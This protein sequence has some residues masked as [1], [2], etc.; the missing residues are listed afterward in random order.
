MHAAVGLGMN[1]RIQRQCID[2]G[3]KAVEEIVTNASLL[4]LVEN[5]AFQ[6]I[7]FRRARYT[8]LRHVSPL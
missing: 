3:V 1:A 4:Q 8:D 7:G 6:Q 5:V 2:A